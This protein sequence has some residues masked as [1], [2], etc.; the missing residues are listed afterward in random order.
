MKYD[1]VKMSHL[2]ELRDKVIELYG[3]DIK[4]AEC[5]FSSRNYA[6]VFSNGCKPVVLRGSVNTTRTR[7]DVLS[8][9]VWVDDLRNTITNIAQKTSGIT[10]MTSYDFEFVK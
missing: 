9:L 10:W 4:E 6:F 8:E 5:H 2:D 7:Q 3:R 1:E